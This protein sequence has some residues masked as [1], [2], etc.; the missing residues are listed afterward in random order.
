M[1][2]ASGC[3]FH[4][5]SAHRLLLDLE[6]D[7]SAV[8]DLKVLSPSRLAACDGDGVTMVELTAGK[9]T[10]NRAV[11][12]P[13]TGDCRLAQLDGGA[14]V[15]SATGPVGPASAYLP[16]QDD[17]VPLDGADVV[18]RGTDTALVSGPSGTWLVGPGGVRQLSSSPAVGT[19]WGDSFRNFFVQTASDTWAF[20][21]PGDGWQLHTVVQAGDAVEAAP[22]VDVSMTGDA[23]WITSGGEVR[24]T[25]DDSS[26]QLSDDSFSSD[27]PSW[28]TRLF[29][30]GSGELLAVWRHTT[31][32]LL[33]PGGTGLGDG[34]TDLD[35]GWKYREFA[36]NG[37]PVT[38]EQDPAYAECAPGTRVALRYDQSGPG[39][40]LIVNASGDA[41]S[42]SDL[43]GFGPDCSVIDA[44]SGLRLLASEGGTGALTIL[45]EYTGQQ[46]RVSA[47]AVNG[48]QRAV[49][50]APGAATQVVQLDVGKVPGPWG[51]SR[52]GE[53]ALA[54]LGERRVVVQASPSGA[55]RLV[56]VG[57]QG[58]SVP[59]GDL[60][61]GSTLVAVRPDGL[62]AVTGV[63]TGQRSLV[64]A[65]EDAEKTV[66][67]GCTGAP[68]VYLPAPGFQTSVEAAEAM[69]PAANAGGSWTDCRTSDPAPVTQQQVATYDIGA[70][71]GLIVATAD[72]GALEV[73]TWSRSSTRPSVVPAP[74]GSDASRLG[75]TPD[76]RQ[77]V[78][79]DDRRTVRVWER[80]SSGWRMTGSLASSVP[81]PVGV[82]LVDGASLVL[83]VGSQGTFELLD[84]ATGRRL[85]GNRSVLTESDKEITAVR[86]TVRDGVLYAYEHLAGS[87]SD[88]QVLD[89]PIS[90]AVLRSLLCEVYAAASCDSGS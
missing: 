73:V 51:V 32:F 18:A 63:D 70:E 69:V 17:P 85:V 54:G 20:A 75:L 13:G 12:A 10:Y 5:L 6:L 15:G 56:L 79:V 89:V 7:L 9:A 19:G 87:A 28:R 45:P 84:S 35:N 66:P 3:S 2:T 83:L 42:F 43:V 74:P 86:T 90:I 82:D 72:D 16:R 49:L 34:W 65:D 47:Y 1:T 23:A 57:P 11:D 64:D 30:I 67:L 50:T 53:G 8:T 68:V 31:T 80:T 24:W 25:G 59:A 48:R 39:Q 29:S 88:S 77:A 44:G 27:D 71:R 58:V 60:P 76:G 61:S 37:S 46:L 36:S 55:T 14:V 21:F 52:S 22:L 33:P 81:D 40:G 41:V 62:G 78:T 38:E 26:V 4:D